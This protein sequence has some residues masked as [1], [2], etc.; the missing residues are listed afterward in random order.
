MSVAPSLL[1]VA[2]CPPVVAPSAALEPVALPSCP[3]GERSPSALLPPRRRPSRWGHPSSHRMRTVLSRGGPPHQNGRQMSSAESA[4]TVVAAAALLA[5]CACVRP[6]SGSHVARLSGGA[7]G[8]VAP[9]RG[10]GRWFHGLVPSF[11]PGGRGRVPPHTP[12][13]AAAA[14]CRWAVCNS[15]GQTGSSHWVSPAP[16]HHG[17]CS[18][19][20]QS[21]LPCSGWQDQRTACGG[22]RPA[23][24][25]GAAAVE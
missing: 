6:L 12:S 24:H 14:W 16:A 1:H 10:A 18:P 19:S 7:G 15:W 23:S 17:N 3:E 22:G 9:Y 8:P 13:P 5:A 11:G 25:V 2:P 4:R 20:A 21:A